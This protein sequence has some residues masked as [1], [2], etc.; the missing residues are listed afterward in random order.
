MMSEAKS[1]AKNIEFSFFVLIFMKDIEKYRN[2]FETNPL[3]FYVHDRDPKDGTF[4]TSVGKVD[5]CK[6]ESFLLKSH[7]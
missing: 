6:Y 7:I 5:F 3:C 1:H 2:Y 4:G